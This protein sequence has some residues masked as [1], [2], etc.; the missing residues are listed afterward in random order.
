MDTAANMEIW[1]ISIPKSLADYA[2]EKV[3]DKESV[4]LLSQMVSQVIA[5]CW[6]ER[7]R[8]LAMKQYYQV[9]AKEHSQFG[10]Q[11]IQSLPSIVSTWNV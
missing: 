8:E 6:E 2:R 5:S 4:D 3:R 11:M 10:K 7:E 1:Q 9:M